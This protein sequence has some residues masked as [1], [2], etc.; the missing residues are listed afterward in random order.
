MNHEDQENVLD[1]RDIATPEE[2][3]YCDGTGEIITPARQSGGEIIDEVVR[4]CSCQ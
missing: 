4:K 1:E 3:P 2:C